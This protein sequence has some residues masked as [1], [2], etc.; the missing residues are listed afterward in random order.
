MKTVRMKKSLSGVD[1]YLACGDLY[2]TDDNEADSLI[3]AGIAELSDRQVCSDIEA[4][5]IETAEAAPV[6]EQAVKPAK[7]S[8]TK[9]TN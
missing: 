3:A 9:K 4:P 7:K 6:V 1:Y 5:V 2:T 8:R